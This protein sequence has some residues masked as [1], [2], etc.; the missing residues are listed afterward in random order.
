MEKKA[1]IKPTIQDIPIVPDVSSSKLLEYITREDKSGIYLRLIGL[2]D[3]HIKFETNFKYPINGKYSGLTPKKYHEYKATV[4]IPLQ[5]W[6]FIEGKEGSLDGFV[7]Y[8]F[9]KHVYKYLKFNYI[10]TI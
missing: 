3:T 4:L 5:D 7:N 1:R 9:P 6:P 8:V 10:M 2:N